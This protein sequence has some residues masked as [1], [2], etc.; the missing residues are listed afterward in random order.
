LEAESSTSI[1]QALERAPLVCVTS[2]QTAM[3]G[4]SVGQRD[5]ISIQEAREKLTSMKIHFH[6]DAM[7]CPLLRVANAMT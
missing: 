2:W 7:Q 3:A 4:A 5:H 6:K 1:I